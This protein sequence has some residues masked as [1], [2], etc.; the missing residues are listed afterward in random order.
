MM[1][2]RIPKPC[3]RVSTISS[4]VRP[5][6]STSALGR[7]PVSGRRRVPIPAARIMARIGSGLALAVLHNHLDIVAL[8]QMPGHLLGQIHGAMLASGAAEAD[9]QV[10][11]AA[12][13]IVVDA[14]I[15]QRLRARQEL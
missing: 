14:G 1:T 11:E 3:R 15:D 6:I 7:S 12:L 10:L 9:H 8:S 2:W 13:Q 4:K 5:L